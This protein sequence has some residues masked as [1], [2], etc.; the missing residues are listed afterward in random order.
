M[1]PHTLLLGHRGVSG[2]H[3]IAENTFA[4]FDC[5]MASGCDGFEFDVRLTACGRALV[6]HSAKVNGITVSRAN[7]TQLLD[8]PRLEDVFLRYGR[9]S[10][11]NAELKVRGLESRVLAALRNRLPECGYLISSFIPDVLLEIKARRSGVPVG[12]ICEKASQLVRWRRLPVEYVIVNKS[13]VTRVLVERIQQTGRKVI[14]WTVNHARAMQRFSAW[15]VDG[16]ISDDV[17]LL[18]RTLNGT[19]RAPQGLR[20]V[21]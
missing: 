12:I 10:F 18:A 2:Q 9:T 4:A 14:V 19:P 5:A 17:A 7:R 20:S 3:L 15:G 6:C 8:L 16:I 1:Q 13:L 11:L 21:N